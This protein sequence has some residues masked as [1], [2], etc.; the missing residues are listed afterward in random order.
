MTLGNDVSGS[1]SINGSANVTLNGSVNR[2]SG[3]YTGNGG[4]QAPSYVTSGKVRFN[5]MNTNTNG[6]T[7][8]KDFILMDTYTGSDV[9]YVTA[10]G[11]SKTAIPM[12]FI[13]SGPRVIQLKRPGF[14]GNWLQLW[15][16]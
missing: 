12:A 7:N 13:M 4:K 2:I 15:I 16:M 6:N 8:Y 3:V 11:I 10:I 1:V 9:P 14:P 5:M